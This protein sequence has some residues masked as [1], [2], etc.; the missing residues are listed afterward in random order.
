MYPAQRIRV[1]IEQHKVNKLVG[2]ESN[3][4]YRAHGTEAVVTDSVGGYAFTSQRST[5]LVPR[6][7]RDWRAALA[8]SPAAVSSRDGGGVGVTRQT[9]PYVAYIVYNYNIVQSLTFRNGMQRET[10]I[11]DTTHFSTLK[12]YAP[13]LIWDARLNMLS[14]AFISNIRIPA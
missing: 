13:S 8:R 11:V 3:W 12:K 9:T 1:Q 4:N 2:T 6:S 10:T 5:L 7:C 14:S